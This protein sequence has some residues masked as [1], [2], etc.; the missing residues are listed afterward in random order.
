MSTNGCVPTIGAVG[1]ASASGSGSFVVTA[2]GVEGQKTGLLFYGIGGPTSAS[3]GTTTSVLCVKPPQQRTGQ[4]NSGGTSGLCDGA[5]SL[6]FNAYLASNPTALGQP[7]QS[8]DTVWMQG[9][10][11]DPPNPKTTSLTAALEFYL[12]P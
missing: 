3:W 7:F 1:T 6:D 10:Y 11:R 4:S 9:W 2:S 12:C 5:L 8:G